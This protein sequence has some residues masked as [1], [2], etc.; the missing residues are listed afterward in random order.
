M[1]AFIRELDGFLKDYDW[2]YNFS[3]IKIFAE[4][5]NHP[6]LSHISKDHDV[7]H[8]FHERRKRL[9]SEL[10][11]NVVKVHD[12]SGGQSDIDKSYL[13]GMSPKKKHEC[14]RLAEF[15]DKVSKEKNVLD[16]GSGAG[17]I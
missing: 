6:F 12:F 16:I 5:E 2:I 13:K 7:L 10:E 15:I 14:L 11:I 1:H 9:L 17:N 4:K 8:K 3:N